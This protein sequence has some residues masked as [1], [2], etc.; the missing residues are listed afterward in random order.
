MP[1]CFLMLLYGV[2]WFM[3][4]VELFENVT[5]LIWLVNNFGGGYI[6][7]VL[8]KCNGSAVNLDVYFCIMFYQP[9][10]KDCILTRV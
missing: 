2:M 8:V 6:W 9:D 1:I 7:H 4:S 3:A 10:I 5:L